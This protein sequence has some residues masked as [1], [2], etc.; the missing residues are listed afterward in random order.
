VS[1]LIL[2]NQPF[3][4]MI[5]EFEDRPGET[6]TVRCD[7]LTAGMLLRRQV[8]AA[9]SAARIRGAEVEVHEERGLLD[10]VFTVRLRGTGTQLLPALRLL[11]ALEQEAE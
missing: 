4:R 5:A 3:S 11:A 1:T 7:A 10:S 8:R 9:F 2:R 6:G